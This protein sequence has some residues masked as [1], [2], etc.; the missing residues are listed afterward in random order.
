MQGTMP[1]NAQ[2]HC[3]LTVCPKLEQTDPETPSPTLSARP[4]SV[5]PHPPTHTHTTHT[6]IRTSAGR[7]CP[8]REHAD[9]SHAALL[10]AARP[11]INDTSGHDMTQSDGM[12]NE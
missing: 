12:H 3:A 5:P 1:M 9:N 11:C 7:I 2:P 10:A 8:I 4:P 6:H